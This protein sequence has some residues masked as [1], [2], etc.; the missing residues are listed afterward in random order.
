MICP[1]TAVCLGKEEGSQVVL[2]GKTPF[3]RCLESFC[4]R[5]NWEERTLQADLMKVHL[6]I[7]V[8][9]Q[10][11]SRDVLH[12]QGVPCILAGGVKSDGGRLAR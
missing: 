9:N 8:E 3:C 12:E 10:E 6:L 2:G 1:S 4:R 7:M 5:L 11:I